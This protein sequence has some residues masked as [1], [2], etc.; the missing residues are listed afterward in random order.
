LGEE[1]AWVEVD[2]GAVCHN[3]MRVAE[4]AHPARLLVMV[5][6]DGYGLGAVEVAKAVSSV[7]PYALGVATLGEAVALRDAGL[8][9]RIIVFAPCATLEAPALARHGLDAAILGPAGLECLAAAGVPLHLEIDTGMGRA[10]LAAERVNEWGPR[11]AALIDGG[12]RL[13]TVFTHFHSAG[14]DAQA[15]RDQAARFEEALEA[16]ET[17]GVP[18]P[19]RH[20]ANSDAIRADA[21]YHLDLVRPGLYLYGG[22]CGRGLSTRLPD[23]EPVACVRARVLEVRDLA[24]G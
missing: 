3:A 17:A 23:S 15:T 4:A 11:L 20:A 10:G 2:L 16:L 18:L 7:A 1:R 6:A 22:G 24:S 12:A 13:E 9:G 8:E 14:H 5:K 21:Q 19:L